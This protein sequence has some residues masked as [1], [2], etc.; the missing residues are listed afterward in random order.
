MYIYILRQY[1]QY[2]RD[3]YNLTRLLIDE[4]LRSFT[5]VSRMCFPSMDKQAHGSVRCIPRCHTI[6]LH[7]PM[8]SAKIQNTLSSSVFAPIWIRYKERLKR[9]SIQ[10][11]I[12]HLYTSSLTTILLLRGGMTERYGIGGIQR[13]IMGFF[14]I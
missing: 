5:G 11:F 8:R 2:C 3:F 14:N 10:I 12:F 6:H 4:N 7:S 1:E 9:F 13:Q